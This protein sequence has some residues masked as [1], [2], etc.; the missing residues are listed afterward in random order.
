MKCG[1]CLPEGPKCN[2]AV[3][4]NTLSK[5]F[6]CLKMEDDPADYNFDLHKSKGNVEYLKVCFFVKSEYFEDQKDEPILYL[7]LG[8]FLL[9]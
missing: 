7:Y 5:H 1:W 9:F 2:T 8:F 4:I 6:Y 3:L